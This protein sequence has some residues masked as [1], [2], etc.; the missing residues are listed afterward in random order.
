MTLRLTDKPVELF[1]APGPGAPLVVLNGEGDEGRRVLDLVR[2]LT[3]AP[4]TLALIGGIDWDS[5][6]TPWPAPAAFRGGSAFAGRADAYLES[7][8]G[9]I[10]PGIVAA[11]GAEPE[12]TAL[13]GYSLAG[14]FALYAL[15][16][17]DAFARAASVSGS[18]WYPGFIDYIQ[19][20]DWPRRPDRLYLSVGDREAATRNPVMK[21]VAA[22]T[23]AA[24]ALYQGMGVPTAFELN[25]GGHF[26]EPDR[27][28]AKGIAW[29]LE[30]G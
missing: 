14:L 26:N 16:H 15:Y 28:T 3:G 2:E 21:P 13:A 7:L 17:T 20:R 11:L 5:E 6:L 22:N 24:A 30:Q 18:L 29:L 4:F 27:R 8:T 10:L 9:G 12:Y 1:P 25:P 19:G 23:R